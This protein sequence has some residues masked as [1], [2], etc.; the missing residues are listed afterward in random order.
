MASQKSSA[1]ALDRDLIGS[2]GDRLQFPARQTKSHQR[3]RVES[4][5]RLQPA[6]TFETRA[7]ARW[8]TAPPGAPHRISNR[9]R[10]VFVA[11]ICP[12]L[13]LLRSRLL[14]LSL[15]LC[16]A[17]PRHACRPCC[18]TSASPRICRCDPMEAPAVS[19]IQTSPAASVMRQKPDWSS[20][21]ERGA[22][23]AKRLPPKELT[24]MLSK[25]LPS[26]AEARVTKGGE[27]R[28]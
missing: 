3:P 5:R 17:C 4:R 12:K 6:C 14:K 15:A 20:E 16:V 2:R 24:E 21:R 22:T 9:G 1:G 18:S 28:S 19:A 27:R 26:S 13:N 11:S 25:V 10:A 7:S 8:A 23:R